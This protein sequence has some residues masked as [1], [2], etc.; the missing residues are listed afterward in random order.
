MASELR[1]LGTTIMPQFEVMIEAA[2]KGNH[3]VKLDK[4]VQELK[5]AFCKAEDLLD[6]HEYN[7][8]ERQA[9]SGKGAS[10]STS[11]HPA[12][13][14]LSNL[15]SK[16]RK[17]LRQLKEL[18]AILAEGKELRELLCLPA[19]NNSAEGPSVPQA[20]S[21]PPLKIIGRDKDR[22]HIINFITEPVGAAT[23][24]IYSGLAIVGARGMGKSTLAQHVYNDKRVQQHFDVRMWCASHADLMSIVIHGRSSSPRP[25]GTARVLIIRILS[26]AN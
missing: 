15:H 9:K 4:W 10:T 7:L 26:R 2:N 22:D 14:W 1:E 6:M 12:F 3:R 23:D 8:L 25:R 18:K 21:L 19:D 17:L 11:L 5:E 13:N 20:T 16:N 24:A